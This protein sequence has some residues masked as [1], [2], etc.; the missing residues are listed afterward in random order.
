MLQK[1]NFYLTDVYITKKKALDTIKEYVGKNYST[2]V[3]EN[4]YTRYISKDGKAVARYRY[5]KGTQQYELNL[6]IW[7]NGKV[8]SN[9]H[10]VVK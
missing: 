7:S 6:E 9:Y 8:I 10:I 2:I 1:S 3:D 4:R 5:K